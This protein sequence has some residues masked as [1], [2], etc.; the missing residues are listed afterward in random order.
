[1]N[2]DLDVISTSDLRPLADVLEKDMFLLHCGP[3]GDAGFLARFEIEGADDYCDP[4]ALIQKFCRVLTTLQGNAEKL[5]SEAEERGID[6]GF[7]TDDR[8]E[9]LQR[10]LPSDMMQ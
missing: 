9:W 6:L 1:M 7:G 10:T 3:N 4:M 5:W 2:A 8:S